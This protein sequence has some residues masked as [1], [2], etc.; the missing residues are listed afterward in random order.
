MLAVGEV[1]PASEFGS[2]FFS[3]A[4]ENYMANGQK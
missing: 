3:D 2:H 1:V 4:M